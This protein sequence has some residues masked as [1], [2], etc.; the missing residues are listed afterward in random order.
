MTISAMK[1]RARVAV[2]GAVNPQRWGADDTGEFMGVRTGRRVGMWRLLM[3]LIHPLMEQV[4]DCPLPAPTRNQQATQP[5]QAG[6]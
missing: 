1:G 3:P 5:T 4:P 6:G 2:A